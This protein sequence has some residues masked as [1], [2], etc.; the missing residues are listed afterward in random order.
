ML[1]DLRG[2][3]HASSVD[4]GDRR[5][6]SRL[7]SGRD[8]GICMLEEAIEEERDRDAVRRVRRRKAVLEVVTTNGCENVDSGGPPIIARENSLRRVTGGA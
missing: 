3:K 1:N 2:R 7:G 8:R 4:G 5:V 6:D